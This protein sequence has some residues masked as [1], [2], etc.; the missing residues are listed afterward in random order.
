MALG[1]IQGV[2][3]QASASDPRTRAGI[4]RY[5]VLYIAVLPH[6]ALGGR[7]PDQP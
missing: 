7:T 5:I 2:Y 3:L 6:S 1:E 4:S